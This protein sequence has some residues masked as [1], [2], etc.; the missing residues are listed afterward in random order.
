MHHSGFKELIPASAVGEK[1]FIRLQGAWAAQ[2]NE[3]QL[4][5]PKNSDVSG[6]PTDPIFYP[7]ALKVLRTFVEWK[8]VLWS[9]QIRPLRPEADYTHKADK[10]TA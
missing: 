4:Q 3:L 9:D 1:L 6:Y 8:C 2:R 5:V 10:A 7:P